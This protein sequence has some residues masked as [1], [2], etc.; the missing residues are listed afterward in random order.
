M[1]ENL[2]ELVFVVDKSG[3]MSPLVSDTIGGYNGVLKEQRGKEGEILVTTYLF[4]QEHEKICGRVSIRDAA[5]MTEK[6]YRPGG[7]T[8][9]MDALG[10]ALVYTSQEQDKMPEEEKPANTLFVVITDGL[11]NASRE[12][13]SDTIKTM[14][15]D[16]QALGWQ[17]IFL[18]ANIDAVETAAK[19]GVDA[20]SAV[21]YHADAGGMKVAYDAVSRGVDLLR[22]K[23][24]LSESA[25]WRRSAD[26]DFE[27]RK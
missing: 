23:V 21:D 5:E 25:D 11:E 4:N 17:F 18:G 10:E 24:R 2:T 7:M 20:S 9:L 27:G 14:I 1:K 15:K 16:K 12:Y 3:S 26:E 22:K 6:E 19:Y 8:A 13:S